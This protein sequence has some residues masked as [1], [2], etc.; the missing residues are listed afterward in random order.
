MYMDASIQKL[1]PGTKMNLGKGIAEIVIQTT[2]EYFLL[3]P[4]IHQ[5]VAYFHSIQSAPFAV[6]PIINQNCRYI[7]VALY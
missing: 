1:Y 4:I 7:R 5:N 2:E 6:I 3:I